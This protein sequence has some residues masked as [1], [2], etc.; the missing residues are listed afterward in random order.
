MN[1]HYPFQLP[2]LPYSYDALEPFMDARTVMLHHGRHLQTY[3]DQ[4]NKVLAGAPAYHNWSLERLIAE[5]WRLPEAMQ[6]PVWHN[7]GGVLNHTLL[8][9]S[10]A[11]PKQQAPLPVT[12]RALEQYF[13]SYEEFRSQLKSAALGQFGSG[14]AWLAADRRGGLVIVPTSNQDTLIPLHLEPLLP[15]DVWEHAYYLKYQ[16]R[17][18]D[19]LEAWFNL[20][21]WTEV[22]WRFA[23][24]LEH[25]P[26]RR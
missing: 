5:N 6:L 15:V 3:V 20:I 4:L 8:F 24:F 21:N 25:R 26:A 16:N 17:R 18:N 23:K 19:Y 14:W 12:A 1:E 13:G 7:A 10:M 2:P 11:H 22:E 9:E